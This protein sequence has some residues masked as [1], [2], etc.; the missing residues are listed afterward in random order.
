[1]PDM[2]IGALVHLYRVKRKM[3]TTSLATH[4]GITVRYLEMIEADSKT[5]SVP[6]L[7][8][9]AKVLGVRTSA[10]LGEAPSEDHEGSVN[11]RLAEVER[12][13]VTYRSLALADPATTPTLDELGEQIVAAKQAWYTSP[14]KYSDVLRVLPDLIVHS[15]R[16]VYEY[17]HSVQ[18]CRQISELYQLAR[19]VLKHVGR[20]D[21]GSVVSDRAMRYA[22]ETEDPL[23]IA[24][25][26]WSLAHCMIS[27]DMPAGSLEVAMKGRA[28]LEPL[29]PD[30]TPEHFSL[31]GGLLLVAAIASLRTGD[32]WRARELLREPAHKAALR[33]GDGHNYH[34]TVFGPTNVAIHMVSVEHEQGE[35]TEALRLADDVDISQIPSLER[36][37]SHLYQVARCYECRNND[38]AVFVHLK[39][40]ERI[41]PQ[42]FQHTRVVRSMVTT[43]VKR[44]KPSY[45]PEVR[46]F[47]GR[48]GLLD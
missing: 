42:D 32:P 17:N 5:P 4:A 39:M 30:G 25:A 18:A 35:I 6:V 1:M 14:S 38:A 43:L 7:R 45:A 41:C 31:Y 34:Q 19:Q 22:E 37:T 20:V 33:V 16:A 12:A 47:A 40:A 8:K 24:A 44:A 46:E 11:P 29:L 21:L 23:V 36:Q 28:A 3:G 9:L 10:L 2:P 26:T 13:L 15:E 27:D 48:I